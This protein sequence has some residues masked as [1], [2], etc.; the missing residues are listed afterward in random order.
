MSRRKHDKQKILDHARRYLSGSLKIMSENN[1]KIILN[2]KLG[3]K[4]I[5]INFAPAKTSKPYGGGNFCLKYT[6]LCFGGCLENTGHNVYSTADFA[7][8][9]RSVAF[10]LEP[11]TFQARVCVE[12]EK[13]FKRTKRAGLEPS[14]R[15]NLLSDQI[16]LAWSLSRKYEDVQFTDYTKRIDHV[17]ALTRRGMVSE[18]MSW[19][20]SLSES[21]WEA[22]RYEMGN[23]YS[24]PLFWGAV[25]IDAKK[26][27]AIPQTFDGLHCVDGD[28]HD[29]RWLTPPGC[30]AVLRLKGS[31]EAKRI[32]RKGFAIPKEDPRWNH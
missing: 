5:G 1:A 19:G 21:N 7:R 2:K 11:D 26:G 14:V 25:V 24:A 6:P 32:A 10:T 22:W 12:L 27:E 17:A 4:T 8:I 20:L 15:V 29:A 3:F 16:E 28:L 9:A 31:K 18:N 13:F 30:V 23:E